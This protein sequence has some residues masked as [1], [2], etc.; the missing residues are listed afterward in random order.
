VENLIWGDAFSFATK[1]RNVFG[2]TPTMIW[3]AM[4]VPG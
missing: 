1:R 2:V 3:V 4:L